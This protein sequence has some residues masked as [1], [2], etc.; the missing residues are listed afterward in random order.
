[1]EQARPSLRIEPPGGDQGVTTIEMPNGT[2]VILIDRRRDILTIYADPWRVTDH[3]WDRACRVLHDM[4][5]DYLGQPVDE[6]GM[7]MWQIWL[8]QLRVLASLS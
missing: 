3:D 1:M 2:V 6:G 8:S 4:G 7:D 5:I